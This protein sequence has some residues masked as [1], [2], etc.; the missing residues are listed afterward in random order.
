MN[1]FNYYRPFVIIAAIG[2]LLLA[3]SRQTVVRPL[4]EAILFV[5]QPVVAA[6][7][8]TARKGINFFSIVTDL[9]SLAQ[10]NSELAAKNRELEAQIAQLKEVEHENTILRQELSFTAESK[11][12][13]IPAQLIGRTTGGAIKDLIVNRGRSDGVATGQMAVAQGYLV[14]VVNHVEDRQANIS[15]LTHPRSIIPVIVQESRATGLLRGGIGGLTMTDL[16]I[17][18][19][20]KPGDTVITSGLGGGLESG[21]VVGKVSAVNSKSGDITKKAS[22]K[23]SIDIAKLEM[24]FIRK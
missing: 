15:L 23:S 11:D 9:K 16:L 19:E 20:V 18:A 21:V 12:T 13:Y 10:E 14:G 22:L 4:I 2:L 6:E 24:I 5:A 8:S 1:S 3:V 17:D 7:T